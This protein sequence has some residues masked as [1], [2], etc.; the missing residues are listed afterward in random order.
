MYN[1]IIIIL[2]MI[3]S[4]KALNIRFKRFNNFGYINVYLINK[5]LVQGNYKAMMLYKII[6]YNTS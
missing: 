5:N 4:F 6:G 3:L 1:S 2:I